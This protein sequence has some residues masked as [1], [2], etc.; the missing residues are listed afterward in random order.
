[1]DLDEALKLLK[2]GPKTIGRWNRIRVSDKEIPDFSGADFSFAQFVDV[3][4]YSS[5]D[6]EF[7]KRSTRRCEIMVCASGLHRRTFR[8]GRS[9]TSRSTKRSACMTSCS[10]FSRP[11]AWAASGSRPRS[12][13]PARPS[14]K[15]TDAS[16]SRF[17]SSTLKPSG[18][19][20]VSTRILER[21]CR[22]NPRVFQVHPGFAHRA[23]TD[24]SPCMLM[25]WQIILPVRTSSHGSPESS[26]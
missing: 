11:K 25:N 1:M 20:N 23:H 13:G 12:E 4:L 10:W 9:F 15:R 16:S 8:G 21:L 6:E 14:D 24:V 2:G 26:A 19:G 17:D 3:N 5:K 7:A 18:I 22:R